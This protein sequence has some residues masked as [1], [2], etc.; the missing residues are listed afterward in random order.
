MCLGEWGEIGVDTLDEPMNFILVVDCTANWMKFV[1][2]GLDDTSIL[3]DRASAALHQ[4][5]VVF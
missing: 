2:G 1:V 5:E 3:S 4:L